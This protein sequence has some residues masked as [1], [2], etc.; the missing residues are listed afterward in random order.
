MT[1]W[2]MGI[3]PGGGRGAHVARRQI[4]KHRCVVHD[5]QVRPPRRAIWRDAAPQSYD[6]W[7]SVD[8]EGSGLEASRGLTEL[9]G[10]II[11]VM[12]RVPPVDVVL[13]DRGCH[14]SSP[15]AQYLPTPRTW[16]PYPTL[17]STSSCACTQVPAAK[18]ES[19]AAEW[20]RLGGQ[21]WLC[22]ADPCRD[23]ASTF[24]QQNHGQKPRVHIPGL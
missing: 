7:R 8:D 19:R 5:P 23:L 10:W 17:T 4:R 14:A 16:K 15:G 2:R 9:T 12:S 3:I 6:C 1:P 22:G 18:H 20:L 21:I 24:H 13:A 11:G